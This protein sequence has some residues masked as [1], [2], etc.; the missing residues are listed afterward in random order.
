MADEY[1]PD[2][3]IWLGKTLDRV[4]PTGRFSGVLGDSKHVYGYHRARAVLPASDYSVKLPADREGPKWAASAVDVSLGAAQM[5]IVSTRLIDAGKRRDPR[6]YPLR[7]FFGTVN[8]TVVTGWD[9]PA[10]E[11]SSSPDRSHLSHIHMSFLRRYAEDRKAAEAVYSLVIGE[12][13]E[14]WNMPTAKEIAAELA[15]NEKFLK[16][17]GRAVLKADDVIAA[18]PPP[19]NNSDYDNPD[20]TPGNRYWTLGYLGGDLAKRVRNLE[21]MV[22]EYIGRDDNPSS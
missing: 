7:E 3:L 5:K 11:Y 15:V 12:R 13:L 4:L 17:V 10:R 16:A 6:T 1:A 14:D 2:S 19:H 18:V 9:Y 20:G 22:A 8:G 21:S